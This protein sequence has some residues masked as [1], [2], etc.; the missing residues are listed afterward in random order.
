[1]SEYT[2]KFPDGALTLTAME[3]AL[4]AALAYNID[5]RDYSDEVKALHYKIKSQ[6]VL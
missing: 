4:A 6:V 3:W 2:I 1:M 5:P